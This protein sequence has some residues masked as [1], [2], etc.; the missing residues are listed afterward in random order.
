MYRASVRLR[1]RQMAPATQLGVCG[2]Q[3]MHKHCQHLLP[4]DCVPAMI[5]RALP[6]C[7]RPIVLRSLPISLEIASRSSK[8][9]RKEQSTSRQHSLAPIPSCCF[10]VMLKPRPIHS[11]AK[12]KRLRSPKQV[13]AIGRQCCT[14]A[15]SRLFSCFCRRPEI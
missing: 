14:D 6:C 9:P 8:R 5:K 1:K 2:R 12:Q 4:A 7:P 13:F 11:S 3:E 10:C 15:R